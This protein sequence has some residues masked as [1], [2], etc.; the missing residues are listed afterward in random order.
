[1]E[2]WKDW[3]AETRSQKQE[4]RG[5]RQETMLTPDRIGEAGERGVAKWLAENGYRTNVD[6]RSPASTDI[7]AHGGDRVLLV[8]VKSAVAPTEPANLSPAE[9]RDIKSRAAK[10]KYEAWEARVWLDASLSLIGR[11]VWRKIE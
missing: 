3:G 11:I 6:T 10:L 1:M 9:E 7:L 2:R 5:K 8:Q 4:V